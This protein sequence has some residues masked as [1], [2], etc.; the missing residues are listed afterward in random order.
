MGY[1]T[2]IAR[3]ARD[4][5]QRKQTLSSGFTLGLGSFAAINPWPRATVTTITCLLNAFKSMGLYTNNQIGFSGKRK[6]GGTNYELCSLNDC[7][8]R[9]YKGLM[10]VAFVDNGNSILSGGVH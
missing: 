5:W 3:F 8:F 4:L 10:S 2:V 9:L 1:I 6:Q 7:R